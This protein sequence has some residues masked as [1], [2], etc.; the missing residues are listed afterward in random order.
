MEAGRQKVL[1]LLVELREQRTRNAQVLGSIPSA[2]SDQIK[3]LPR[4]AALPETPISR[5]RF[6]WRDVSGLS[7]ANCPACPTGNTCDLSTQMKVLGGLKA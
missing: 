3:G 5:L 4:R 2:G 1:H 7:S 6:G